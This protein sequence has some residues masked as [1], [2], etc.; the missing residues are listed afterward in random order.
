ME[1]IA[2]ESLKPD[3]TFTGDLLLDSSFILLPHT[4]PVTKELIDALKLWNFENIL[5]DG[6]ISLGGD[7]GVSKN[8]MDDMNDSSST[9]VISESVKKAIESSK[10]QSIGDSDKARMEMVQAVYDEYMNYIESVFTHYATHK[11]INQQE[12]SDTVQDLCIFIKDHKRYIL[13][14]NPT[15][16]TCKKN[17]LVIHSMRTTVLAIAIASQLH[18]P[19]SKM[20]ELGVS[21]ILHEIGMLRVPPQLYMTNKKLTP[22]E[23]AQISKHTLFGY[24]IIKDLDFPLVVQLG[25]LEHH[26]KEN[27]MGYPRRLNSDKISS[28]AKIIAV[29]C[30]YEAISSVR[31]YKEERSTFDALLEMLQ[32]KTRQYDDAV[33]KALLFT[34][35]LYPIGTYVYLSNRKVAIVVDTNPDNPKA[36][37]VQLLTEKEKDGSP[38]VIQ[39]GTDI[40]ILR[41]LSK[42]ERNDILR[43]L[44]DKYKNIENAQKEAANAETDDD[45]IEEIE[46]AIEI[47][48]E[49]PFEEPVVP[50]EEPVAAPVSSPASNETES[51]EIHEE[52]SG[53]SE[54][55]VENTKKEAPKKVSADD[56]EEID[57]SFFN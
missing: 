19:L 48:E 25:V 3:L 38:K 21:C 36:P 8:H 51:F 54:N 31:E 2:V 32:N 18:L 33:L 50:E 9:A 20:I 26:E 43:L 40:T 6:A 45:D 52:N 17:F 13:R 15:T 29:A 4:A 35:S 57:I 53:L 14:I 42:H 22:G 30:S 37:I 34:V 56:T 44:E 12:L 46:E 16:E 49:I 5:C 27:G 28:N 39:T 23:R 24:Q 41:I 55:L 47:G 1:N 11:Q 7:I 10:S